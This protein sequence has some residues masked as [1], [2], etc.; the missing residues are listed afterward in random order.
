[1]SDAASPS[2][3]AEPVDSYDDDRVQK[4]C[5]ECG[6]TD[7]AGVRKTIAVDGDVVEIVGC[8]ECGSARWVDD[9]L[10]RIVRIGSEVE[11]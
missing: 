3:A 10:R 4:R 7:T 5:Q 8:P 11:P 2:G 6:H 9:S 1:M